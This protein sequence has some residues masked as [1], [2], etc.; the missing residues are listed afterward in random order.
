MARDPISVVISDIRDNKPM[1]GRLL[2]LSPLSFG[3]TKVKILDQIRKRSIT[4]TVRPKGLA[5][6]E[7]SSMLFQAS[8]VPSERWDHPEAKVRLRRPYINRM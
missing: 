3:F 8:F 7:K 2:R 4:M 1:T 5:S 6:D